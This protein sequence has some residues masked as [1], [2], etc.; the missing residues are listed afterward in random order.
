MKKIWI[1]ARRELNVFFDSLMAYILLVAFM[2]FTGLFTWLML[3]DVFLNNQAS[4]QAFF[5]VAYW[6]L[7]ILIPA[8]TMRM[9]A[10]EKKSGTLEL[11]LTKPLTDWQVVLGKFLGTL[12][13]ICIALALSLPYYITVA[14]IGPIDHGAVWTGYLGL[15]LMSATYISIGIFTSSITNNQIVSFLLALFIG[16]FFHWVFGLIAGSS[17]GIIGEIFNYLSVSNH[18]ESVTRGVV[19]T[20]DL[21]FFLSVIFL[22]LVG[23]EASLSKR[24]MVD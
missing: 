14:S 13:L 4:L 19:D 8:I 15:I 6:S 22:A 10:E 16:I 2:A 11:L 21:I 23:T 5:G 12:L 9:I 24:N 7:F 20:K 3:A 17:T 1:I 18:Y